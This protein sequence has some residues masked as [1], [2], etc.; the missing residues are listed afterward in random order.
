MHKPDKSNTLKIF[1][2]VIWMSRAL[3]QCG[4]TGLI[5]GAQPSA[6]G[7][8]ADILLPL[9]ATAGGLTTN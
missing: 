3:I 7:Q 5:S 9:C 4:I 8:T 1:I 2:V 6:A